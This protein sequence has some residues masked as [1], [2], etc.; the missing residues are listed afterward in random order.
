MC[1]EK[2]ISKKIMDGLKDS[3]LKELV[4]T[5]EKP[6][7]GEQA[8][9]AYCGFEGVFQECPTCKSDIYVIKSMSSLAQVDKFFEQHITSIRSLKNELI[10]DL[11]NIEDDT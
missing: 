3:I 4:A 11:R 10:D 8:Y 1:K 2:N 5:S 9:C 7:N 6:M